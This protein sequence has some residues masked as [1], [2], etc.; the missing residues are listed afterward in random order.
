MSGALTRM[1]SKRK[2]AWLMPSPLPQTLGPSAKESGAAMRTSNV[3]AVARVAELMVSMAM[4]SRMSMP[5]GSS[6]SRT[7]AGELD[8][9][10]VVTSLTVKVNN[11]KELRRLI[12]ASGVRTASRIRCSISGFVS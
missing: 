8:H 4:T 3:T 2:V 6:M 9:V 1:A 12:R 11:T 5:T 7:R 10:E